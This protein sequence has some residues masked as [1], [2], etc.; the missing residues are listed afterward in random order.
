MIGQREFK[1]HLN[2]KEMKNA[3]IM[4]GPDENLIKENVEFIKKKYI[5]DSINE[6][7]YIEF[8]GLKVTCDEILNA[9]ETIPFGSE[10]KV[11]LIYRADM[12]KDRDSDGFKDSNDVYKF[13]CEYIKEL[14]PYTVF[15]MYYIFKKDRDKPSLKI[16]KLENKETMAVKVDKL[17]GTEFSTK[18]KALFQQRGV[19]IR[20]TELMLFCHEV[21][22]NF[23]VIQG[24]VE[25]LCAYTE[26]RTITKQDIYKLIPVKNENDIFNLISF[27]AE[28]NIKK[29][30]DTL[31]ELV[32]RGEKIPVI[33]WLLEK[34]YYD[35]LIIKL[36]VL[37]GMSKNA[38]Q[39]ELNMHPYKCQILIGQ[40]NSFTDKYLSYMIGQCME[41]EKRIK[42]LSR[43]PKIDIEM[44]I[45]EGAIAKGRM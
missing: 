17:K 6:F 14:P 43:E 10:K 36:R 44:L 23:S 42:T 45:V 15:I 39:K 1:R 7:N 32:F 18:V 35:L 9:C 4:C 27:I 2:S 20:N 26:G 37:K 38:I 40:C 28:N 41:C 33:L 19:E 12:L 5:G 11:V 8:D 16:K 30:I 34:Q 3:Y 22:N 24:E 21:Q 13:F 31:N 29:A 25:K